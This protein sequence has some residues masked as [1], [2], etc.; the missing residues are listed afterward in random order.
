MFLWQ[1]LFEKNSF[2]LR[3]HRMT[4]RLSTYIIDKLKSKVS[5][6]NV[7]KKVNL[8]VSTVIRIFNLVSYSPQKLPVA[9]SIDEFKE[10]T[11][12]E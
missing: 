11:N 1:A 10:N 4:N 8:S 5:F 2:L 12:G 6:S 9:L 7:A 3:Y